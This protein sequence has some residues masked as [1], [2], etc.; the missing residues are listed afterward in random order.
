[1]KSA[2]HSILVH[3]ATGPLILTFIAATLRFW[4]RP[5]G[6]WLHT[7]WRAC[8]PVAFY[9]TLFGL[10]TIALTFLT[11]L[12][13]RPL[14]AM[15]NSPITRNKILMSLLAMVCWYGWMA[16][17]LRLGQG[18]WNRGSFRGHFAY[19]LACAGTLFLISTNSVGGDLAGIPSGYEELAKA[20][21]FQTRHTL[22]FP[23]FV[24]ALL[25][26]IGAAAV[27][28]GVACRLRRS[29]TPLD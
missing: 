25:W 23:T 9:A 7:V 17:R 29:D 5:R 27:L 19:M 28:A 21:G 24:N 18:I 2:Y 13:I 4:F 16:L 15:L 3:L 14:E 8:D 1:M 10:L 12:L 11:G 26:C 20:I 22:Y 6:G